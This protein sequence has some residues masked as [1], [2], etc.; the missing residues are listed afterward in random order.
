[1]RSWLCLSM[2][3]TQRLSQSWILDHLLPIHQQPPESDLSMPEPFSS[4][5][6]RAL[7]DPQRGYYAR[8]IQ[9]IGARGDFSTTATL[10]PLLGQAIAAWIKD[11]ARVMPEVRHIIEVGAGNGMLMATV[12]QSLGWWR[13]RG[14]QWHIV[15]TSE[16]LRGLQKQ[17]L[18]KS[19]CWHDDLQHALNACG[20]RAFIYHNELLDAFP[21]LLVQ[22][23][24]GRWHEVF[25]DFPDGNARESLQP[26]APD[27]DFS[28]LQQAPKLMQQRCEIHATVRDWLRGW[29]PAWQQGSMLTIDYGDVFPALYDRRP[30][31][32]LRAY[33]MHQRLE[34]HAIY[35]NIGRQDITADINFTDYRA[36]AQSLGWQE[37]SFQTQAEFIASRVS[38]SKDQ[39]M[40]SDGA[41][42][43][44]KVVVHR[45]LRK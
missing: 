32:T 24:E 1:M 23:H 2:N 39:I 11:E 22:W 6:A 30:H 4:F 19:V 28:A 3:E 12:R 10:S 42:G 40:D 33:L 13:R 15:E 17:S 35:Q 38:A 41:G 16:S 26:F 44:F 34:G 5:M 9:T 43:A 27:S 29:A 18:G 31:G 36:W 45:K 7:H 37:A 25:V 21:V 20:G 8:R 14:F